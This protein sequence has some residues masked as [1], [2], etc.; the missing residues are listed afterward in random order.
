V[1]DFKS[2]TG[3]Q[4]PRCV[5]G[6]SRSSRPRVGT[7]HLLV[8]LVRESNGAANR[9]LEQLGADDRRILEALADVM[10]AGEPAE[11]A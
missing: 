2:D 3:R 10:S 9:V 5:G 8:V 1:S 7:E 4:Q 11:P 6:C